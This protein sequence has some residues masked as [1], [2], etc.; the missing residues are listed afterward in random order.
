MTWGGIQMNIL[1]FV[2]IFLEVSGKNI[3]LL[4]DDFLEMMKLGKN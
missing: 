4:I 2:G 1:H 3:T